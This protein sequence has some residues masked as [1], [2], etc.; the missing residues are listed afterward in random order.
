MICREENPIC[1]IPKRLYKKFK[2]D[3]NQHHLIRGGEVYCDNPVLLFY[4][5]HCGH[6]LEEQGVHSQNIA[7]R[8]R[9]WLVGSTNVLSMV[10]ILDGNQKHTVHVWR[11][12]GLLCNFKFETALDLNKWIIIINLLFLSYH[13]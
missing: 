4:L 5:V 7:S 13:L 10:L 8:P 12:T 6:H 9:L 3:L 1:R 2:K 11:K